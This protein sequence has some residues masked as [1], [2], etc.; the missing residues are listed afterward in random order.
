MISSRRPPLL[1]DNHHHIPSEWR[2]GTNDLAHAV[3]EVLLSSSAT[4]SAVP[5]AVTRVRNAS[6]VL[7]DLNTIEH[8]EARRV[9]RTKKPVTLSTRSST[10]VAAGQRAQRSVWS[11]WSTAVQVCGQ[12]ACAGSFKM[13]RVLGSDTVSLAESK[14]GARP[15]VRGST[16]LGGLSFY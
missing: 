1:M 15:L 7:E 5:R 13:L 2:R 6:R 3:S 4:P 16:T 11:T 10:V 9:R 8:N 12:W 14:R